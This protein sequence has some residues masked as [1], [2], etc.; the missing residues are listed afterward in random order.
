MSVY[1]KLERLDDLHTDRFFE[2]SV[3]V[4]PYHKKWYSEN[5]AEGIGVEQV[6]DFLKKH[7]AKKVKICCVGYNWK[8][9]RKF[10]SLTEAC[11]E[12]GKEVSY[13][14]FEFVSALDG[15]SYFIGGLEKDKI[16][17]IGVWLVSKKTTQ[18]YNYGRGRQMI[19]YIIGIFAKFKKSKKT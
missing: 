19:G 17:H 13:I 2:Q 3:G 14:N 18:L 11:G 7:G 5:V 9:D 15:G 12:L 6:L 4:Y 16:T 10:K 8:I 1:D